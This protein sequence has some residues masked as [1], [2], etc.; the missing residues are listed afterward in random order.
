MLRELWEPACKALTSA[1]KTSR[2][3]TAAEHV[4]EG[5]AQ[6]A[7]LAAERHIVHGVD[8]VFAM[9]ARLT[10]L[11]PG[12]YGNGHDSVGS[13]GGSSGGGSGG[14][15]AGGQPFPSRLPELIMFGHSVI[16]QMA[17]VALFELARR[18]GQQATLG[19]KWIMQV[20]VRL[21]VSCIPTLLC[22][23]F[24]CLTTGEWQ[25]SPWADTTAADASPRWRP[26]A[27]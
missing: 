3:A 24:A 25:A 10:S 21:Y 5:F 8:F 1:F 13:V 15:G 12:P 17:V 20:I 14:A 4:L 26:A 23:P 27:A 6:L 11:L 7:A 2:S 18:H 16:P 9:L 22:H 19:W